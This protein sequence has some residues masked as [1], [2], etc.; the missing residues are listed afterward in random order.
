ML[1]VKAIIDKVGALEE[2]LSPHKELMVEFR[3]AE[4]LRA[5][6]RRLLN[7][8]PDEEIVTYRA[9]DYRCTTGAKTLRRHVKNLKQLH[10]IMGDTFYEVAHITIE[11]LEAR[12]GNIAPAFIEASFTGPRPLAFFKN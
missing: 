7:V 6:L 5:E 8:R 9:D 11:E 12:V 4:N 10:A 2:K 3:V 1:A